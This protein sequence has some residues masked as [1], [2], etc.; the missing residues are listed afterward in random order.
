MRRRDF[1]VLAGF[2]L[3]GGC[4]DHASEPLKPDPPRIEMT[5]QVSAATFSTTDPL[6]VTL[7]AANKGSQTL[8][9]GY[10]SSSCWLGLGG[11]QDGNPVDLGLGFVCTTD[12]V[13]KTLEPGEERTE[14]IYVDGVRWSKHPVSTLPPGL[15]ELYGIFSDYRSD[16][17]QVEFLGGAIPK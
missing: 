4:T 9:L 7:T 5:I 10:G 1:S 11:Q 14:I 13:H 16:P 15:Y 17:I 12:W 6:T 3:F 8:D 2:V